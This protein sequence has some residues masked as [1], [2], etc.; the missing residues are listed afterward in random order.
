[1]DELRDPFAD[2]MQNLIVFELLFFVAGPRATPISILLFF[3][4]V[5]RGVVPRTVG[6]SAILVY[7]GIAFYVT[8][9]FKRYGGICGIHFPIRMLWI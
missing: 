2:D 6:M 4:I 8:S 1:M 7:I 9:F 5:D 3:E